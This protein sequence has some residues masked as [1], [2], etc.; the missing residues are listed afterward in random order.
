MRLAVLLGLCLALLGLPA[1]AAPQR[2]AVIDWGLTETL[3]A[4][5]VTPQAVAEVDGYR[6]WVAAPALPAEVQDLGL[7]TEPNLEL[8]SQLAPEL[9]LITPQFE[10]ARAAL[11]RIAPVRSLTL[12]A[13]DSD[14]YLNAQRVTRELGQLFDRQAEAEALIRRVDEGLARTQRRLGDAQRPLYLV[15]FMDDRHVR[16]YGQHSLYQSVLARL[17]LNNAWTT[18]GSYWGF[19]N[20]GI[21]RLI[22]QPDARLLYFRPLPLDAERQLANSALWQNLPMVRDGR[23]HALAEVWSFGALP[24]AERFA[25][26]LQR[27]LPNE[28]PP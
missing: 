22:E 23:V 16:V 15:H 28:T 13:P 24:S 1:A 12:F 26:Q 20:T 10:N 11:E 8:L 6:R 17:G 5:G 19:S 21:E 3:L 2:V 4:L 27:A 14:P 9:I 25:R 18:P 7:R